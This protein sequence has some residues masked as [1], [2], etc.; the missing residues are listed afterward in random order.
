MEK[1]YWYD[2]N[3][4]I[5]Y[6]KNK[7]GHFEPLIFNYNMETQTGIPIVS[8]PELYNLIKYV[9][10]VRRIKDVRTGKHKVLPLFVYQWSELI[11]I[12]Y[13]TL[14]PNSTRKLN[15]W[16][17]QAGKSELIKLAIGYLSTF[18]RM[19]LDTPLERFN[20]IL[21]SHKAMSVKKLFKE[22]KKYIYKGVDLFNITFKGSPLILKRENSKL[23]DNDEKIEINRIIR[24]EQLP[25]S[26]V[27]S[28]TAKSDNDGF[29]AHIIIVDEAGLI[30]NQSFET[31]VTPFTATTAGHIVMFGLPNQNPTSFLAQNYMNPE[32]DKQIYTVEDIYKLRLLTDKQM[33]ETYWRDYKS[34]SKGREKSSDIRW[35]YWIDFESGEGKFITRKDL[36]DNNILTESIRNPINNEYVWKVAGVDISPKSDYF[37]V[38]VGETDLRGEEQI[39]RVVYMETFNKDKKR[40]SNKEKAQKVALLCKRF[41]IDLLV[42][43]STSQ[44]LYF[45][46]I[47]YKALKDNNVNTQFFPFNYSSNKEKLFNYLEESLYSGKLKLLKEDECWESSKLVE[48]LLYFEKTVK[49]NGVSFEAPRKR[50]FTDDHVNSLALF[51]Y[52]YQYAFECNAQR[53]RFD[54]GLNIWRP[55]LKKYNGE[56]NNKIILNKFVKDKKRY[57]IV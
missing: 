23:E 51:N 50:G 46:Q 43:D 19:F 49:S 22:T 27:V 34:R 30:D 21:A 47:L 53:K 17:R 35:N 20:V 16:S 24:D 37:S 4:K 13:K 40:I 39:N 26:Q 38:T 25:Y 11:D 10:F 56:E 3:Y 6:K 36:E 1:K 33:A 8:I 32:V 9:K 18:G 31:S 48:E 55:R 12:V 52:G 14:N 7:S 42:V 57:L 28:L 45:I 44:Q 29:S 5:L 15:A 41:N 54:D 2:K